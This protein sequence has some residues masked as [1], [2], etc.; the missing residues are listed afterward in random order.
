MGDSLVCAEAQ[1]TKVLAAQDF[2]HTV[3]KEG[4]NVA[5]FVRRLE[6]A[7]RIAYGGDSIEKGVREAFLYGQLQE[8]LR[9]D[10][11][12]SPA[13]SGAMAYQELTMAAKN[14]EQRLKELRKRKQYQLL[15][16][17]PSKD[18]FPPR[19]S[20]LKSPLVLQLVPPN[21]ESDEC[22]ITVAPEQRLPSEEVRE[23]G[24]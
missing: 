13:V 14:E 9:Q 10:V 16:A 20:L 11:M 22:A 1:G 17:Y 19:S 15:P 18:R 6:R 21:F 2:R 23:Q 7:F 4:E 24:H 12:R 8:G 3:Q 5:D